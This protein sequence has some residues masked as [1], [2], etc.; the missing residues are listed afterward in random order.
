MQPRS[1]LHFVLLTLATVMLALAGCQS[2]AG[3]TPEA[4]ATGEPAVAE[5]TSAVTPTITPT[6]SQQATMAPSATD[7]VLPSPTAS[8]T[9]T[10]SP[11]NTSTPTLAFTPTPTIDITATVAVLAANDPVD[12]TCPDPSPVKPDY[13]HFYLDGRPWP[14]P[15]VGREEHFWLDKPLPG[16]GRLLVT[17]WLPYG[18]DA[19]GRYLLHNGIDA[20]EPQGTPVLAAA[21][22]TVIVSGEDAARLFGWR[23]DWYGHLVVIEMDRLWRN[24]PVYLVYGHVLNLAVRPG[25]R[26]IRGQQVA[27]VGFGGAAQLP[28]L[29]F[30]VRVGSN[31]FGATRNPLLWL[32]PPISRGLI[33][34]RLV[35]PEGR[36]W[37]GVTVT[38]VGR[39][40]GT[41]N[42]TTWTY[43]GDPEKLINPDESLAENFVLADLKPGNYELYVELQ[44]EVY[45]HTLEVQGG[46]LTTA[47]I[48]TEPFR[49]PTPAP[50]TDATPSI[51]TAPQVT[52]TATASDS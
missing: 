17:E 5:A 41:E 3:R 24:Q 35:D 36:P 48:V 15:E 22:G 46:Q 51:E 1:D 6:M 50:P 2:T 9:Q 37:Q 12:R 49:T 32:Q 45:T 26:V 28:H 38:A 13:H 42:Q 4:T 27:E 19:G 34:G 40:E 21:D 25:E 20:A 33:A 47:E 30:E 43:L 7:T 18:Y 23:C 8:P 16:G 31:E 52:E 29:H 11:T 44:G 39:T 10:P 14:A